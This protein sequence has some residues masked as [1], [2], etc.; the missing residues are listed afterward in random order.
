[1]GIN[2][3]DNASLTPLPQT[4][5]IEAYAHYQLVERA[6]VGLVGYL[7]FFERMPRLLYPL[8]IE[9]CHRGGV[10]DKAVQAITQGAT[11]DVV[12]D[13]VVAHHCDKVIRRPRDLGLATQSLHYTAVLFATMMDAALER[14]ETRAASTENGSMRGMGQVA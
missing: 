10:A 8:W 12:R 13:S 2:S 7:W 9:A 6:T 11:I 1:M 5:A 4:I 3:L 14:A